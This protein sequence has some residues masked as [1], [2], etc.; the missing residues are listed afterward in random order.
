MDMR[1]LVRVWLP[2]M[3]LNS[4]VYFLFGR[5]LFGNW[6]SFTDA[7]FLH[8]YYERGKLLIWFFLPIGL[9]RFELWLLG[10]RPH[11]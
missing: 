7:L 3:L 2:M 1:E 6:E 10:M 8:D 4:P 9:I 11:A 5:W